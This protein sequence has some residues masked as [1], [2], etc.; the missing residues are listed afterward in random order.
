MLTTTF[1]LVREKG[2]CASS[3]R[4]FARHKGGIEKY[5]EDTPFG[6]VEVASG[7]TGSSYM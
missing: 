6:L 4:R 7:K 3:Y 2:A 5:G 1:R